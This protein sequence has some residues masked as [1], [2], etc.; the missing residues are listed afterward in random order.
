MPATPPLAVD[1]AA[2]IVQ[3]ALTPIFLLTGIASL[4]NVFSTRLGRI[5]DQVDKLDA[6][7]K[8]SPRRLA[9]LRLRSRTL[10]FA[11]LLAAIA[12][13][14]TCAAAMTLFVGEIKSAGAGRLLFTLFGGALACSIAALAAFSIEMILAGRGTRERAEED[15]ETPPQ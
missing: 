10:D 4:L 1:A 2:H 13:A 9:R 11:V 7:E 3:L 15:E 12:G 6:E 8:R 5:S 14:L